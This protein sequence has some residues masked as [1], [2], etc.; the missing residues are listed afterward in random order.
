[1]PFVIQCPQCGQNLK[2]PDN[3]AGKKV[4]CSK[5]TNTFLAEAVTA[6][7]PTAPPPPPAEAPDERDDGGDAEERRS[8]R[9]SRDGAA[10]PGR[11][12]M[13]MTFG[14]V[15]VV[16]PLVG[17]LVQLIAGLVFPPLGF[18]GWVFVIVGLALGIMAWVMGSGDLKKIQA[19]R[20][21]TAAQSGT[22]T[23]YITGIIG[24]ILNI[25][26]VLCNCVIVI[27]A[28]AGVAAFMGMAGAAKRNPAI[29]PRGALVLPMPTPKHSHYFS[30]PMPSLVIPEAAR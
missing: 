20:I 7:P 27:L 12:G 8:R 24:T 14:I 10:K 6:T 26:Y 3:L 21:D 29:G 16:M 2:V 5:C 28:I 13:I 30:S 25:L 4:R 17:F 15:S 22:K 11:G 9:R 18:C 23:G 19:G 1:M